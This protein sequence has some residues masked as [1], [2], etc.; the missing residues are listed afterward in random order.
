MALGA[1]GGPG[2]RA[3]AAYPCM[4]ASATPH[5]HRGPKPCK[6]TS[7]EEARDTGP[8]GGGVAEDLWICLLLPLTT[9]KHQPTSVGPPCAPGPG[10]ALTPEPYSIQKAEFISATPSIN[11]DLTD[12]ENNGWQAQPKSLPSKNKVKPKVPAH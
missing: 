5:T 11:T 9:L 8:K 3:E 10:P 1:P 4:N 12:G 2:L 7:Q 6:G